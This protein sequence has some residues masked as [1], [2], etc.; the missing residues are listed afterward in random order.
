MFKYTDTAFDI[1]I[2]KGVSQDIKKMLRHDD[3]NFEAEIHWSNGVHYTAN[4]IDGV[5]HIESTHPLIKNPD[6]SYCFVC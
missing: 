3:L 5:V 2:P 6:G 4:C 1:K